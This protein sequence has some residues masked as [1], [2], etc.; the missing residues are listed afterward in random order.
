MFEKKD[1]SKLKDKISK[2]L[3]KD[4]EKAFTVKDKKERTNLIAEAQEKCKSLFEN[5]EDYSELDV[6]LE[7]KNLEKLYSILKL[8][9][10]M[11]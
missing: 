1:L 3:T 6:S 10:M 5:N 7:L 9:N 11:K 2:S 8:V 4:L